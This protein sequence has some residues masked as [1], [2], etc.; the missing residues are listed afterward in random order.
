MTCETIE[1]KARKWDE[2]QVRLAQLA[3]EYEE[4]EVYLHRDLETL[5]QD[6]ADTVKDYLAAVANGIELRNEARAWEE[7]YEKG[8]GELFDCLHR[9]DE[10]ESIITEAERM[11]ECPACKSTDI[12]TLWVKPRAPRESYQKWW[13]YS[14]GAQGIVQRDGGKEDE[15]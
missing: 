4:A 8:R 9:L 1:K 14:C 15:R 5:P 13:C 11:V 3:D 12:E 6:Y 10:L 7:K 2:T